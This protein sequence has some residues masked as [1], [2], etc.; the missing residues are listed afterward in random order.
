[1]AKQIQVGENKVTVDDRYDPTVHAIDIKDG[2]ATIIDKET[3]RPVQDMTATLATNGQQQPQQNASNGQQNT[4][5]AEQP[6][7]QETLTDKDN[8]KGSGRYFNHLYAM[9]DENIGDV[10]NTNA[11]KYKISIFFTPKFLIKDDVFT[12]KQAVFLKYN[13]TVRKIVLEDDIDSIGLKG[14]IEVDNKGSFLDMFLGR[15]NNYYLVITFTKYLDSTSFWQAEKPLIKYEPYIFDIASVQNLGNPGREDKILRIQLVDVMTSILQSHSIA[16]VI[17]FHRDITKAKSYKV[18]FKTILQYIKEYLKVNTNNKFEFKKD[19]LYDENVKCLGTAY[20]GNDVSGNDMSKLIQ[21]SFNKMSRNATI[22]QAMQQLLAD[23][24]TTLKNPKKFSDN[25]MTIG[26]VLI[27]FFFKE[28]YPDPEFLY[29]SLWNSIEQKPAANDNKT[30]VTPNGGATTQQKPEATQTQPQ[31]GAAAESAQTQ[32][33]ATTDGTTQTDVDGAQASLSGAVNAATA[34]VKPK[35]N[36]VVET[37]T[38]WQ[39]AIQELPAYKNAQT[40]QNVDYASSVYK[41]EAPYLLCRQMTM[42]DIFMPFFLAFGHDKYS[43]I[44]ED[45]NPQSDTVTQQNETALMGVYQK[46]IKS[47]SFIPVDVNSVRKLWKNVIFLDCT[48]NSNSAHNTLIFFS[49][50]FD[51]FQT[52]FLNSTKRGLISNVMPDF[53]L[54]SKTQGIAHATSDGNKFENK[55][56]EYNSYTYATQTTDSV[57]ECLRV[58]G[59][60]L[61]SFTLINDMYTFT[62]NGNLMRRPNEIVKFGFRN[63]N[64]VAG[65]NMLSMHTDINLGDYT[66]LYV[67]RVT[68]RFIGNDYNNEIVGCKICEV[69]NTKNYRATITPGGIWKMLF[70]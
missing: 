18:V 49:W 64:D 51:F 62:L 10:I 27:P 46:E 70:S 56:D 63:N 50:F 61:A 11:G 12:S 17:K 69:M 36:D 16:S 33:A 22:Y 19:L 9:V 23:C 58:M 52:V 8:L 53:F 21:A 60:N 15:H 7:K 29:P 42:R 48:T 43:G 41:G 57:N 34:E 31:Q 26:D 14:Y 67:R 20:N 66:Y 25:Y 32:P 1:M 54:L 24:C 47:L 28:E 6:K 68:H 30:D 37:I 13:D 65:T 55:F 5:N 40:T 35:Q 44:Y 4:T 39:N 2:H 59:K 38:G 3:Q 45:I